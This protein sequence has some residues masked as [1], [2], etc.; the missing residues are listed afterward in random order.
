MKKCLTIILCLALCFSTIGVAAPK[1]LAAAPDPASFEGRELN[2]WLLKSFSEDA[3]NLL[4]ARFEEFGEENGVSVN[5]ELYSS[6]DMGQKFSAAVEADQLPDIYMTQQV[7]SYPFLDTGVFSDM[8]D[9]IDEIEAESGEFLIKSQCYVDGKAIL[10]PFYNSIQMMFY[11]TDLL[12]QAG[13]T[14]PPATWEEARQI[15]KDVTEKT[16]VYGLGVGCGVDEDGEG[17]LNY[18]LWG[19]GGGIFMDGAPQAVG[20]EKLK[21]VLTNYVDMYNEDKSIPESAI[22]WDESGN[23]TAYLAGQVAIVFNTT[24]LINALKGEGLEE[25]NENTGVAPIPAGTEGRFLPGSNVGFVICN[26]DNTDV[27]DAA[28]RTVYDLDWYN[29]YIELVAPV[30]APALKECLN[31]PVWSE[32]VNKTIMD[33]VVYKT[34]YWSNPDYSL[35]G[36]RIGTDI[37]NQKLLCQTAQ[38]MIADG[39]TVDKALESLQVE[40]DKINSNY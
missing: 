10:V 11:R 24:T 13:Y 39:V 25:I 19:N 26:T 6:A 7:S 16:G 37:Y 5:V 29:Q 34:N 22:T 32:G 1:A 15:A 12:E 14:E 3:N 40:L 21:E 4:A 30:C 31:N 18:M 23:N 27:A 9:F 28:L 33:C 38:K 20:N 17:V 36:M 35:R 2:V 8:S